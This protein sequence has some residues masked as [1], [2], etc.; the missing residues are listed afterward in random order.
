MYFSLTVFVEIINFFLINSYKAIY[1]LSIFFTAIPK[2]FVNKLIV[3][4]L[5]YKYKLNN[6]ASH[7]FVN[8]HMLLQFTSSEFTSCSQD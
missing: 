3:N 7:E 1:L 5:F 8:S 6:V 2:P 4:L